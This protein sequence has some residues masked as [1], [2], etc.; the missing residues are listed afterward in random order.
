MKPIAK[1]AHPNLA[2]FIGLFVLVHFAAHLAALFGIEAQ[3]SA[4]QA[5]RAVYQFPV[6]EVALVA[7]LAAQVVLGIKLL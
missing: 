4:L 1:Q 2:L 3:D 6:V 7:A 5:G